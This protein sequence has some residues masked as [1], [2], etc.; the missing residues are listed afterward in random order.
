MGIPDYIISHTIGE[1]LKYGRATDR[2]R[3]DVPAPAPWENKGRGPIAVLRF[4]LSASLRALADRV[5]PPQA[6]G[7]R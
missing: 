1:E 3:D 6:I 4:H 7:C 2:Y 5:A